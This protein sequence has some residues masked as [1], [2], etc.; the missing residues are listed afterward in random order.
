MDVED[1][2]I[3]CM[4]SSKAC[5][6]WPVL[7]W[8]ERSTLS[9]RSTSSREHRHL[10]RVLCASKVYRLLVQQDGSARSGWLTAWLCVRGRAP[11][12]NHAAS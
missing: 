12:S 10:L 5:W 3:G 1:V 4:S 8:R 2:F 11:D 6:K 7:I 9:W